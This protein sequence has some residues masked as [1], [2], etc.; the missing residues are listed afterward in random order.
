MAGPEHP[1]PGVPLARA[2]GQQERWAPRLGASSAVLALVSR[3]RRAGREPQ[4]EPGLRR[5]R[6]QGRGRPAAPAGDWR[7]PAGGKGPRGAGCTEN[8]GVGAREPQSLRSRRK[9]R[10]HA[11]R[12]PPRPGSRVPSHLSRLPTGHLRTFKRPID[13]LDP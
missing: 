7:F 2:A 5:L 12:R 11:G 3:Q 9:D 8:S 6:G 10:A 1:A 13:G 4:R